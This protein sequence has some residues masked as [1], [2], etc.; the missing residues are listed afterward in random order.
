MAEEGMA[1]LREYVA[2]ESEAAFARLVDR[3]VG[4]VYSATMRQVHDAHLAQEV[5]H[6][7]FILLARK[8]KSLGPN[9]ILPAWLHRTARHAAADALK[10]QRRRARREQEAYMRSQLNEADDDTWSQVA[11]LLDEALAQLPDID[12]A[13]LILR[14]FEKKQARQVAE[15]LNVTE[16]AAQKRITRAL[17]KLRSVFA[18]RGVTLTGAAIAT[19]ISTRAVQAAPIRLAG[20]SSASAMAAVSTSASLA[21]SLLTMTVIQKSACVAAVIAIAGGAI[22]QSNRAAHYERDLREARQKL[23]EAASRSAPAANDPTNDNRLAALAEE[24]ARLKQQT[25]NSS[26]LLRLRGE[27]GVLRQQLA[28][29][30]ATHHPPTNQIPFLEP[31]LTREAWSD[32]GTDKPLN[33]ILTLFWAL[34]EGNDD[35][36]DEL[37]S[38]NHSRQTPDALK[39]AKKE[40]DRITA[41]QI[42]NVFTMS[43]PNGNQ[44]GTVQ[45]IIEKSPLTPGETKELSTDQWSLAK[46]NGQWLI[47]VWR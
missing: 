9:T 39:S 3:Y 23:A 30:N 4:F 27:V 41:V 1:D 42:V 32:H 40:R 38:A 31:Y 15:A 24:N 13:A 36:L 46:E 7:V 12:R 6:A 43:Q 8:A 34:R 45:A 28:A 22:Y 47:T 16:Q 11:P 17:E 29:A 26:E 33:T 35:R 25:S 14:F 18:R 20:S 19:V 10:M 21:T 5:T 37:V 44:F 2:A